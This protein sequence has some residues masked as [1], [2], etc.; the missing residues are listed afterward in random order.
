G[1][2][3][4][5]RVLYEALFPQAVWLG[6]PAAAVALALL[7]GLAGLLLGRALARRV[8]SVASLAPFLPLLLNAQAVL[9]PEG[10]TLLS[11]LLFG[12]SL[13]LA[14]AIMLFML[15]PG[16][17]RLV[18]LLMT[19]TA[20]APVYLLTMGR[21]VGRADTFEFQVV[22]PKLGIVHPT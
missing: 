14:V 12:G 22:I 1:G 11:R 9:Q 6:R 21:T 17:Q 3:G 8:G 5:S 20:L 10:A 18:G 13:W 15:W 16:G 2:L 4:L 19:A 7:A